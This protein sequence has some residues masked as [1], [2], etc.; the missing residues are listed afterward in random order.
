MSPDQVPSPLAAVQRLVDRQLPHALVAP[1]NPL[2]R[3][4]LR[5]HV[6][7]R[8]T[9]ADL[10]RYGLWVLGLFFGGSTL[11]CTCATSFVFNRSYPTDRALFSFVTGG[12]VILPLIML[13]S[14]GATLGA[15]WYYILATGDS[16]SR[17]VTAG[18]WDILRLTALPERAILMAKYAVVQINGWQLVTVDMAARMVGATYIGGLAFLLVVYDDP[19]GPDVQIRV[20][21]FLVL[22]AIFAVTY[23]LEPLWRMRAF[24]AL[25]LAISAQAHDSQFAPLVGFG[26]W[27]TI[28]LLQLTLIGLVACGTLNT[29]LYAGAS[30]ISRYDFASWIGYAVLCLIVAAT[31]Y[32]FYKVLQTVCLR[33]AMRFA[34]RS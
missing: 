34:F 18:Q 17:P 1:D 10:K 9:P 21:I 13:I 16:I 23:V 19:Y 30:A 27:L 22:F 5:K 12:T 20:I 14:V 3:Y 33:R 24:T 7:H 8:S 25:G 4:E 11:L 2:F 29:L 32:T 6:R 28:R 15:D 31:I 26:V